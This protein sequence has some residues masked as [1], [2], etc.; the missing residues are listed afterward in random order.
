MQ[1]DNDTKLDF[2]VPREMKGKVPAWFVLFIGI[3]LGWGATYF[4]F[5]AGHLSSGHDP[6]RPV[7]HT[8]PAPAP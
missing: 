7:K 3:L 1:K 8:E 4:Y 6:G 2:H 5:H